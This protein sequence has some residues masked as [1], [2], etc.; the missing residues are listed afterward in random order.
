MYQIYFKEAELALAAYANLNPGTPN[1][2][3]L[4]LEADFSTSQ[5][6]I[7]SNEYQVVAQSM[8]PIRDF[9]P[10]YLDIR[11]MLIMTTASWRSGVQMSR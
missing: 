1:R 10:R 5:S 7:F 4:Q 3:T 8:T 6:V 9:R 11:V 2:N